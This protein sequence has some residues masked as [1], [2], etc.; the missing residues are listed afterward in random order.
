MKKT[1]IN[2]LKVR[3][4][5]SFSLFLLSFVLIF[6]RVVQLQVIEKE[7]LQGLAERQH[8]RIIEL[9]PT[10]GD[11]YDQN[12]GVLA[13][14][15]EI[16]SLFAHPRQITNAAAVAKKL[17]PILEVK[18]STI[19]K[20]LKSRKPFVWLQR[21]LPPDK[22]GRIRGFGYSGLGFLKENKRYYPN[23]SLAANLLGLVG[24]DSQGLEGLELQYD[25]YLKG[26]PKWLVLELDARGGEI[27]T[28]TPISPVDLPSHSLVLTIDRHLQYIVKSALTQ[29]ITE[30]RARAGMIVVMDPPTG[31]IL[32]MESRPS[33]NPNLLKN[34]DPN[35]IRNRTIADVFEPGS[36]FKIFLLAAALEE[37]VVKRND[38]FFGYNGAYQIGKEIIHDHKK[39]GWL[40]LQKVIKFSSNIGA[41]QIGLKVGARKLDR[42]IRNFGF[43]DRT[44]IDLPGE[45]KG[46]V[47]A[48]D[49]L[50]QVGIANTAFG[51][52]ISVTAV[53]LV[54]ALSAIANGGL[55]M[56]PYI[57]D[58][59]I[60][61]KGHIVKSFHPEYRRR[62]ISPETSA[63]VIRIMKEVVEPG[64]TGTEAAIP[65]YDVAGKTGTAQKIDPF[66]KIYSS[67]R[68]V[69]SFM[70]FVPTNNPRL[71]IL[72]VLDEPKGTPYGGIIAAPVFKTVAQKSLHYLNVP[73]QQDVAHLG[74]PQGAMNTSRVQE[75]ALTASREPVDG[76]MPDLSGLSMRDALG[77]LQGKNLKFRFTGRGVVQ[78]QVPRPGVRL[79][80]GGVCYLKFAPLS[81]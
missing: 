75:T 3:I 9:L 66:L 63:E 46:I 37:G 41:S 71:A 32:A 30:T 45:V 53:Q 33:F 7:S 14:S 26:Q 36:I 67:D 50:S 80:R 60:D 52:G 16:E 4:F 21:K 19:Q 35:S 6:L 25:R 18:K 49:T 15:T 13:K 31:R 58:R 43:G 38:I 74:E 77:W 22:A 54:S 72:V 76:I 39:Y 42:H 27:I 12:L 79:Q 23:L 64:G 40:T 70:G 11:I 68:Y 17:A 28:E 20:K 61:Q 48:A 62:V 2:W 65:G 78:E 44:G 55:L 59:I 73:P 1:S 5:L 56:R 29:T 47:R 81:S 10:R 34:Y 69:S 51:Q 8:Q 57:V 24:V